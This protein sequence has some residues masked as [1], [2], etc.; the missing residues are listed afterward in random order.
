MTLF[1]TRR[2]RLEI[3]LGQGDTYVVDIPH[4]EEEEV[5]HG[6]VYHEEV[7]FVYEKSIGSII[8]SLST[9]LGGVV[10]RSL[11]SR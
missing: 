2:G 4:L 3:S 5:L 1:I 8:S 7:L 9:E 10:V 6:D 11:Y